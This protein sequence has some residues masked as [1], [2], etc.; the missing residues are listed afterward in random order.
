METI[1]DRVIAINYGISKYI[2]AYY[3]YLEDKIDNSN[4]DTDP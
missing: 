1:N 2:E 3:S 4:P